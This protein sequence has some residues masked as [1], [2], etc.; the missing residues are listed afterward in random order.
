M[1]LKRGSVSECGL[2]L[3]HFYLPSGGRGARVSRG[4]KKVPND[5]LDHSLREIPIGELRKWILGLQ[6]HDFSLLA[7]AVDFLVTIHS[8]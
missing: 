7:Q 4:R 1:E 3:D 5:F 8:K 6:D 2:R